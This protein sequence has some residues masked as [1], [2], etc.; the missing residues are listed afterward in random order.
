[1]FQPHTAAYMKVWGGG[2]I[3]GRLAPPYLEEGSQAPPADCVQEGEGEGGR[4]QPGED[5]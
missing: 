4:S 2:T 1:M 3:Q 5:P